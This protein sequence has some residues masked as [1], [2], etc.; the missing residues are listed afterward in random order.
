MELYFAT[1]NLHKIEELNHLLYPLGYKVMGLNDLGIGDQIEE[2][3]HT[4][5]ENALLKA[6]YLFNLTGKMSLGEDTGLEVFELDMDPGVYSARYGGENTDAHK[7]IQKL[8][9]NLK[10]KADRR[11]Q[12][13][14]VIALVNHNIELCFEGIVE[15][16]ITLDLDGDSGFGYD[17]VFQPK[18]YNTTFG[19]M[20]LEE[21]SKISHRAKAVEKLINYLSKHV[22]DEK[23]PIN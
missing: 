18:G 6:K 10:G 20:K 3:G 16:T 12:F 7:N 17:P 4:L 14:T 1:Q 11:A 8:L 19:Q 15:G 23:Y 13:R 2:N 9:L 22:N 5:Q 21:K